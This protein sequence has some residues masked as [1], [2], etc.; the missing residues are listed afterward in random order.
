MSPLLIYGILTCTGGLF[1]TLMLLLGGDAD[2]DAD[3]DIDVG[4]D[5][6]IDAGDFGGPGL[7]SV[8][9]IL[10][11]LTGFGAGGFLGVYY[12]WVIKGWPV[13]HI[14]VGIIGGLILWVIG[15]KAL[16]F[17]YNQQCNSQIKM[18]S[19]L[20]KSARV[21]VPIP[22]AGVGEINV[23]NIYLNARA[24]SP[25]KEYQKGETLIVKSISGRTAIVE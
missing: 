11:F 10:L 6:D 8:K 18:N 15:Y 9:L 1:L 22:K 14:L 12:Q 7:F 4:I 13:P 17:L 16:Q 25:E 20:G 23:E 2:V 19:L 21:V 24:D 5:V 3:V